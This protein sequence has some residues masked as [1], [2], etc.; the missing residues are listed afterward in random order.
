MSDEPEMLAISD[1][2]FR[3]EL[4][5]QCDAEGGQTAWARKRGIARSQVSD[6]LRGQREV[7]EAIIIGLGYQPVRRF[8]R[9]KGAARG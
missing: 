5:Q 1:A 2:Q 9:L 4:S 7:S 6:T 3:R 8:I